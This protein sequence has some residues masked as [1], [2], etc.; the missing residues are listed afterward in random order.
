M[1]SLSLNFISE[2]IIVIFYSILCSVVKI[3]TLS[4][5]FRNA[6]PLLSLNVI[7]YNFNIFNC[8]KAH[9]NNLIIISYIVL[10]S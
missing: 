6:I 10:N 5:W 9:K 2:I 1:L 7:T 3:N 8:H 4:C